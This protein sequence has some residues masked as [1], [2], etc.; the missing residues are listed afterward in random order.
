LSTSCNSSPPVSWEDSTDAKLHTHS[1]LIVTFSWPLCRCCH[2]LTMLA[3]A[4]ST[5]MGCC[6]G[7][8]GCWDAAP[9]PLHQMLQHGQCLLLIA[10]VRSAI[11][12]AGCSL[13]WPVDCCYFLTVAVTVT[14]ALPW[15]T[16][17]PTTFFYLLYPTLSQSTM[18]TPGALSCALQCYFPLRMAI[19]CIAPG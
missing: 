19:F 16:S 1:Q 8:T 12:E 3:N 4:A 9:A 7:A 2:C 6:N 18:A 10:A 5:A 13:P 11:Q 17:L 14:L 15:L